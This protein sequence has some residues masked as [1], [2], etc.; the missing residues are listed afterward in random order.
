MLLFIIIVFFML[1]AIGLTVFLLKNDHGEKEPVTALWL[2]VGFGFMAA[3][4][5][6]FLEKKL[7]PINDLKSGAPTGL[8]LLASVG[9]GLIEECC[10]FLPLAIYI[11]KKRYFNEHTDGIIYFALAGLGFGLPENILY[12]LQ[13][14]AKA[15]LGRLI[16]TPIF[17]AAITA[18]VGY[19]LVKAKLQKKQLRTVAPI[20]ILAIILHG[21]YD[22][23]L[24]S[25]SSRLV[26]TSVLITIGLSI[27]FF[28]LFF[29]A[30]D[31]DRQLGLS[32]V[33]HNGYCRSCGY[34]NPKHNLY[35]VHCGLHA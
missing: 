10:K 18:M 2:A 22:F 8:L 21:L 12:T 28:Y 3:M 29:R 11:Y 30:G 20:L 35:C 13:F 19:F 4:A 32:A 17:H 24:S 16:L 26:L 15:G 7:L 14:G 27:N 5:A 33:G 23:G 9:V 1:I 25:G 31:L 34:K 6:V